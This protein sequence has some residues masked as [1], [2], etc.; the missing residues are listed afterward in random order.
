MKFAFIPLRSQA[1]ASLFGALFIF[2]ILMA[3][4]F[5]FSRSL[6]FPL[7]SV[8]SRRSPRTCPKLLPRSPLCPLWSSSFSYCLRLR[9]LRKSTS[10]P[11]PASSLRSFCSATLTISS[12]S[13]M[14]KASE[15]NPLLMDFEFP[16][17]DV[18]EGKHVAPGIRAL[19]KELRVNW[20]NWR[21]RWSRPGRSWLSRW[22]RLSIGWR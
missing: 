15:D 22:R 12:P 10:S 21:R 6:H 5:S 11:P 18:I 13:N 2:H 9:T 17:F 14:S 4:R 1:S 19:L 8:C 20:L 3:S 7:Q 16:P